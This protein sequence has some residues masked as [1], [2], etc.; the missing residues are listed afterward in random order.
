MTVC[1]DIEEAQSAAE[2]AIECINNG[3]YQIAVGE[4][5]SVRLVLDRAQEKIGCPIGTEAHQQSLIR[6]RIL[7]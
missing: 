6:R 5:N 4:C 1:K 3:E 2:R 7:R